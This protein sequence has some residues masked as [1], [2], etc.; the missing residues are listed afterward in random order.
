MSRMRTDTLAASRRTGRPAA[1]RD[2]HEA[3]L[4]IRLP[5]LSRAAAPF[6]REA[7]CDEESPVGANHSPE[8]APVV[9]PAG[10]SWRTR[11][12][13]LAAHGRQHL[14]LLSWKFYGGAAAALVAATAYSFSG[15]EVKP[16]TAT[17]VTAHREPAVAPPLTVPPP[18]LPLLVA[19]PG[20]DGAPPGSPF[21]GRTDP[22][23]AVSPE[24]SVTPG[25]PPTPYGDSPYA[26]SPY[27]AN[28]SPV[29]PEP[30][31]TPGVARLAGFIIDQDS[32]PVEA[33]H[34]PHRQSF[35]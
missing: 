26:A 33:R 6:G 34:E 9:E 13:E 28:G 7:D 18:P 8:A 5:D 19:Q 21:G 3:P 10:P 22:E 14:P 1:G 32:P 15:G 4:K 24:Y 35:H 11:I 23:S 25:F 30:P 31:R 29:V 17:K 27:M 16:E 12:A 2:A 20:A